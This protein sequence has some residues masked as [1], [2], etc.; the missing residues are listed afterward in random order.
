MFLA[1]HASTDYSGIKEAFTDLTDDVHQSH[2]GGFR[3]A[4]WLD[5]EGSQQQRVRKLQQ[6]QKETQNKHYTHPES[7][8]PEFRSSLSFYVFLF[9]LQN[10]DRI[11]NETLRSSFS[12][13]VGVGNE[14]NTCDLWTCD[15]GRL[16]S[17]PCLYLAESEKPL[18]P[19]CVFR[20]RIH[21][22][23]SKG[24]PNYSTATLT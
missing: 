11:G 6:A 16:S 9:L 13:S 22:V 8:K 1:S 2:V 14:C 3:V 18:M 19:C 24:S 15:S 4:K 20:C 17:V 7:E 10:R 21:V 5:V 23:K 12:L